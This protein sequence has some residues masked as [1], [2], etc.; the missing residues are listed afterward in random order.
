LVS[1]GGAEEEMASPAVLL[2]VEDF[3]FGGGARWSSAAD[4]PPRPR[5]LLCGATVCGFPLRRM[6]RDGGSGVDVFVQEVGEVWFGDDGVRWR[7]SSVAGARRLPVRSGELSIQGVKESR[8]GGAP[9]TA[10]WTTT[11]SGCSEAWT[12]FFVSARVLSV[13]C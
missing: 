1:T 5:W 11:W 9:P 13:I 7:R 6:P 12:V 10:P 8:S 4:L 3:L 2:Q